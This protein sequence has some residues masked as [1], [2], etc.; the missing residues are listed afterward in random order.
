MNWPSRLLDATDNFFG[1]IAETGELSGMAWRKAYNELTKDGG[2]PTDADVSSRASKIMESDLELRKAAKEYGMWRTHREQ[3][4]EHMESMA[5]ASRKTLGDIEVK[6]KDGNVRLGDKDKFLNYIPNPLGIAI[7]F[8]RVPYNVTKKLAFNYSPGA[9]LNPKL[10]HGTRTEKIQLASQMAIG[11]ATMA[12]IAPWVMSGNVTGAVPKDPA[13]REAFYEARKKPYSIKIGDRWYDYKSLGGLASPFIMA[14]ALWDSYKEKEEQP[15]KNM[16]VAVLK[17]LGSY[18]VDST[19]LAGMNGIMSLLSGDSKSKDEGTIAMLLSQFVPA[20]S[21]QRFINNTTA[22]GMPD[23]DGIGDRIIAGT[24]FQETLPRRKNQLGKDVRRGGYFPSEKDANP[25]YA[26]LHRLGL[27][28]PQAERTF[29]NKDTGKRESFTPEEYRKILSEG[30]LESEAELSNLIKTEEYQAMSDEEKAEELQREFK[31]LKKNRA[32]TR[33]D[34]KEAR[35]QVK[36][37]AGTF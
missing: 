17:R 30:G 1:S 36:Y 8:I 24:V 34:I 20:S 33:E 26:E 37:P 19:Y 2:K 14:S 23:T 13:E 28:V 15:D 9:V 16:S 10:R 35:S 27:G 31:F 29:D 25:V 11:T 7:P 4:P 12:A 3:M 21:L 18:A 22:E 6:T 5:K 32:R